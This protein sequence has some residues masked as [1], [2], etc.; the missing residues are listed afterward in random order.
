M[1][2]TLLKLSISWDGPYGVG[3]VVKTFTDWGDAPGYAGEDHELY[4]LYGRQ[5][6]GDGDALL[7]I[8]EATNQT[9]AA[10]LRQHE[11][12]LQHKW[13]VQVYVGRL[14]SPR[15][16]R[17]KDGWAGWIADV[18]LAERVMIYTYSPHY[19]GRSI[20]ERPLFDCHKRIE[21]VQFGY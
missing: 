16:H 4:Q 1:G 18:R 6:L 19:N 21:P 2:E 5:M 9:F 13:P 17:A 10:R 14:H 7:Y 12:W 15:R 8:G 20:T 11:E 3:E